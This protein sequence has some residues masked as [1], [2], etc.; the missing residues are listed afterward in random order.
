VVA[1]TEGFVP[2]RGMRTWYRIAGDPGSGKVPLLLL[3]GG[4]GMGSDVFEPLE[5]LAAN[6]RAVVRYDQIG[7]GYSDRPQDPG[8]WTIGTFVDELAAVR[9]ALGLD[10]VHLLGWS[11]GGMLALEYLLTRRQD[12]QSL[13]LASSPVSVRMWSAEA[14]RL[15]DALPDH[16]TRAMRRFEASFVP[17]AGTSRARVRPGPSPRAVQLMARVTRH[18]FSVAVHGWAVRLASS[19]SAVPFLRRAAYEVVGTTFTKRHVIRMR[20]NQIPL[21]AVRSLAGM[22]R[23]VYET[24]WGPS[25][26]FAVGNLNSWDATARLHEIAVPTLITS[27]RYDEATPAQMQVLSDGIAGSRWVV[28]ERSTAQMPPAGAWPRGRPGSVGSRERRGIF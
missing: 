1:V 19:L 12:V 20:P 24:M 17:A 9:R 21:S 10:R 3:H 16:V 2:F 11:W 6:G 27:G 8:L 22:N 4:P 14:R 18:L 28:F 26:F 15:R 23:H 5:A 25:E 13:I 7:C